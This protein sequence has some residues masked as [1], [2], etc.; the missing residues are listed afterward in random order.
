MYHFAKFR[1]AAA[2]PFVM[3]MPKPMPI[4]H[5]GPGQVNLVPELLT[6]RGVERAALICSST[7]LGHGLLD[8]VL[9]EFKRRSV[10]VA[11]CSG[12]HPDPTYDE[13]NR[14]L[15]ECVKPDCQ[16][17]IACGGGSVLDT[18]KVAA[19]AATNGRNP[20]RLQGMLKVHRQPLPL[21][22]IPTTAGT[23]S[24][25]TLAAV[26]SDP[27]THQ[28]A[29]VVD[30][31]LVPAEAILDPCLTEGLPIP[32]TAQ[33]AM[34]ALTHA[35]E[36][37]VSGYATPRTRQY[38]ETAV[39]LIF[40]N[41]PR[42]CRHPDDLEGRQ[43]LLTASM[44]AGLAFTATYVGYVHAF[45]HRIG[46]ACGVPHG[47]AC[48]VLLLPVMNAYAGVCEE[49]F[50]RLSDLLGLWGAGEPAP[51]KC[52]AFLNALAQLEEKAG[53]PK[54][55]TAFPA[56][57]IPD[58]RRRAFAECHGVYPVPRYFTAQEADQLLLSVS[59]C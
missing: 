11:V 3:K 59:G 52:R 51:Q 40:R 22:A 17:I 34:D 53:M 25:V 27:A 30:P 4:L 2:K 36:A 54:T 13:V 8:G 5:T 47:L 56:S 43:A 29:T 1:I 45:A 9:A 7:V 6:S 39:H 48:G 38:S 15:A 20:R 12:I 57:Q 16:A 23:G 37:Y 18:A 26:I 58:V 32:M 42:V 50:A 35:L 14:C 31:R 44:Y 10:A 28:K 41:L 46:S 55:L 33:T 21:I 19:A 49:E 24:E